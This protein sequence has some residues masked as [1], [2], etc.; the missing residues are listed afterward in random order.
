MTDFPDNA[1]LKRMI[2]DTQARGRVLT[3][4]QFTLAAGTTTTVTRPDNLNI[5]SNSV[6]LTQANSAQAING[7]ITRIAPG[8]GTF[9]VTHTSPGGTTKTHY[10]VA[11]TGVRTTNEP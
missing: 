2:D 5:S 8:K 4:G 10:Y 1:E 7:D 6:I 9:T 3:C 11:F